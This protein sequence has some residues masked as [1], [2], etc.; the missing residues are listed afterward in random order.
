MSRHNP[1][2]LRVGNS[3]FEP[4]VDGEKTPTAPRL[5]LESLQRMNAASDSMNRTNYDI[6]DQG[7]YGDGTVHFF[8]KIYLA[9]CFVQMF[10]YIRKFCFTV[11]ITIHDSK[12]CKTGG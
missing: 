2:R 8:L 5:T 7:M 6:Q 11:I 12:K 3:K 1:P 4:E 10:V 9:I